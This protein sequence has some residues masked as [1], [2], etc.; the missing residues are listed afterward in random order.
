LVER[1][2]DTFELAPHESLH[3]ADAVVAAVAMK[4]AA[5]YGRAPVLDDVRCAALG[6]GYLGGAPADFTTWRA[7]I[8]AGADHDYGRRRRVCDAVDLDGLRLTVK[9][10]AG[11][12]EEV[13]A[14]VRSALSVDRPGEPALD[15]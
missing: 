2:H 7:G 12:G 5:S 4:R 3:D 14:G 8:V 10:L 9:A 1:V 6:L 15:A 13:R 11:R